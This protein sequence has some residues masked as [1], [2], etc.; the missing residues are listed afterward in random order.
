MNYQQTLRLVADTYSTL[1]AYSPAAV[2]VTMMIVAHESARGKFRR[3]KGAALPALGLTQIERATFD[4]VVKEGDRFR[5]YCQRA[6]FDPDA[7]RFEHLEHD[8][9]LCFVITRARLAMDLAPLPSSP[10]DQAEF[11]KRFWNAGGKATADK[12]LTDWE[13]WRLAN[14]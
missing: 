11:C 14:T 12:Y 1:M 6:G 13:G 5:D 10:L 3:Q 8:D 9:K 4:T 2:Q 7:V